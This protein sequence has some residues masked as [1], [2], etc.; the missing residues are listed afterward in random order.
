MLNAFEIIRANPMAKRFEIGDL[1]FAQFFCP[2]HEAPM[3]IWSQTDH[4]VHLLTGKSSWTTA[5]GTWSGEAGQSVFFKKGAYI[6]PPHFEEDLCIF[7]FFIPDAFIRQTVR[8][9]APDLA[10]SSEPPSS[11]ELAIRVNN[12]IALSAF[13]QAMAV[14]FAGD[15]VPPEA[16]LKLKIKE[17]ITSIVLGQSNP[18]LSGY[19][20]SLTAYDAPP[21][22]AIMEAN[23]CHN[24][25][26]DV[27]AQ[28]CHRS[29]SS[30]KREF[31]KHYGT[32]PGRW[33]LQRRLEHSAS[34]LETT[35]MNVTEI[36]F[37]SG[38]E[39]P[40][41]FCRAFK[42]KYGRSPT[43]YRTDRCVRLAQESHPILGQ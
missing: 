40:S 28:M 4:L 2:A 19:F 23:F 32:S 20:R 22:A 18:A 3:G 36:M 12:D 30:F 29:L 34:L 1:V 35:S 31:Q 39:D 7:L 9:L 14:Y 5:R 42:Q 38:F 25:E 24:L 16:L 37:E 17:L 26:M 33:L 8:E 11:R 43:A 27:F 13:L 41:H 10:P 6:L 21:I 15:E